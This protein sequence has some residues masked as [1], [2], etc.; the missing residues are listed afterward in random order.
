MF[1][2]A[3]LSKT[4]ANLRREVR[5][6]R[7]RDIVDWA[8]WF[9][10]LDRVLPIL[11]TQIIEGTYAP[12]PPT[13]YELPKTKGSFRLITVPNIRDV[14]VYRHVADVALSRALPSKVKGAYFSRRHTPTPIGQTFNLDPSDPYHK[15]FTIWLTY[16]AY[17]SRTLLASPHDMVVVTDISNYFDS[18]QHD[19]LLE[20]MAPLGLPRK[21]VGLLGR[22][23]EAFKPQAGHSPNPR[24]GLAQ[25]ELDCSRELAHVFLFEH[26]RRIT[27]AVGEDKYVRW[28]DDQNI[29]VGSATAARQTINRLTRS[30]AS[31]RLTLNAG[32]TRFLDPD[33]VVIHFQLTANK[34]LE[35][36]NKTFWPVGSENVESARKDLRS[37]WGAIVNSEVAGMGH[38]DK[39]LKRIYAYAVQVGIPDL[40]DR[41]LA[42]LIEYPDLDERIFH[43]FA[44]RNRP[45]ALLELFKAY[46]GA[47]ENLF[48]ATDAAFFDAA[49]RMVPTGK[50]AS[51]LKAL[52]YAYARRSGRE[53]PLARSAA[54]VL[55]YWMGATASQLA[56]LYSREEAPALPKEVA[57]AWLACAAARDPDSLLRIQGYLLG[58]PGDD[59]AR[60]ARFLTDL[61]DGALAVPFVPTGARPR[62]PQRGYYFDT[63]A[64][65]ML[66]LAARSPNTA[67]SGQARKLLPRF[68]AT[69]QILPERRVLQRVRALLV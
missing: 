27:Q 48:E 64:W 62:W 10:A 46:T 37:R 28:L 5:D 24:V 31:Q 40:E 65:L 39:I 20:Y 69:V 9:V 49:L 51:S 32:K 68:A 33:Q 53:R 8:D 61:F 7:S 41:A 43:Y 23:L 63:R 3:R 26:D 13:R 6:I 66:E 21:T 18:I 36:W 16:N 22:L 29:G 4:A 11:R 30:L 60:F 58:H 47:K 56:N 19:L 12:S 42:D 17:R 34:S 25:D 55:L 1:S 52:A 57:R 54:I 35:A 50:D 67:V 2:V 14:V 44:R 59:V 15:F 45:R 38:W